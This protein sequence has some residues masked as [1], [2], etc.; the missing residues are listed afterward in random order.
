MALVSY[1]D[2][3]GSDTELPAISSNAAPAAPAKSSTFQ[4]LTNRSN[5]RKIQVNLHGVKDE[6]TNDHPDAPPSK[7]ARVGAGAFAGFNSMLP[8]PKRQNTQSK[9]QNS[10]AQRKVFSLKTGAE[11][12]F[13]REGDAELRAFFAEEQMNQTQ[14]FNGDGNQAKTQTMNPNSKDTLPAASDVSQKGKVTMFKP[15]SVARNPRKSK[16]TPLNGGIPKSTERKD[17]QLQ[18][19]QNTPEP[20][21]KVSLFSMDHD[22]PRE[23]AGAEYRKPYE[24]LIESTSAQ[25]GIDSED[26]DAGSDGI[27]L[28]AEPSSTHPDT[29]HV[30]HD[31]PDMQS[32]DSIATDLNLSASAK[33]QLFGRHG[34]K[35]SANA[36]NVV[37][38]NTDQEYAANEA[39]RATGEQVQH[40]PV[41]AIA[42]GKHSLRQ[43]VTA[44]T[45]QKDALEESFATARRNKKEAGN[46]YGW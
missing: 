3:E 15:L 7:R 46:K 4:P 16:M 8:P 17:T 39:L 24:P 20:V 30:L 27:D 35:S 44:A 13:D 11:P 32:L 23:A 18:S 10:V 21:P 2:S 37:N 22:N 26:N 14:R 1:S 43:L 25:N 33:R 9:P 36:I 42:P 34:S 45:G 19:T 41:K 38:F 40:N 5:A 31:A 28:T 29:D 12:G 6:P